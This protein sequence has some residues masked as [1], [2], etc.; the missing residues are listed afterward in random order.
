ME[1]GGVEK[2]CKV[3]VCLT[4]FLATYT[5]FFQAATCSTAFARSQVSLDTKN[6]RP[7]KIISQTPPYFS[8]IFEV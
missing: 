5:F 3:A 2:N 4:N 1:S 7:Q 6:V 8:C